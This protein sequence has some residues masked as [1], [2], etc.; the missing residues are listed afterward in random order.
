MAVTMSENIK[1]VHPYGGYRTDGQSSGADMAAGRRFL[2]STIFLLVYVFLRLNEV[3]ISSYCQLSADLDCRI[4][5][6]GY[7]HVPK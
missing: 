1:P 7:L 2:R 6:H 3:S 4:T 5:F